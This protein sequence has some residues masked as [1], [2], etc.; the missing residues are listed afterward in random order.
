MDGVALIHGFASPDMPQHRGIVA[1]EL[2]SGRE[3]W[4]RPDARYLGTSG[5]LLVVETGSGELGLRLDLDLRTGYVRRSSPSVGAPPA[6]TL[7]DPMEQFAAQF[8]RPMNDPAGIDAAVAA[9]VGDHCASSGLVAP[10]EVLE[11]GGTIVFSYHEQL[12]QATRTYRNVLKV[13]DAHRRTVLFEEVLD[14][15]VGSLAPESFFLLGARIIYIRE[16]RVLTAL[17]VN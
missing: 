13:L 4:S 7:D 14:A 12:S 15:E 5:G 10:P 3:I 1:V 2:R 9:L 16:R 6:A 8:P 11:A 17:R